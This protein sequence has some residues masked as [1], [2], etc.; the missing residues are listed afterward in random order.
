MSDGVDLPDEVVSTALPTQAEMER[1]ESILSGLFRKSADEVPPPVEDAPLIVTDGTEETATDPAILVQDSGP[2]PE[3]AAGLTPET[4]IATP[5]PRRRGVLGWLRRGAVA[6][7][8]DLV[9]SED[10]EV[11]ENI[12]PIDASI[13]DGDVEPEPVDIASLDPDIAIETPPTELVEPRKRR[14]L[15]GSSAPV[16]TAGMALQ[17]TAPGAALPFGEVARVC[18]ARAGDLGKLVEQAARKG[19]GYKLYDS[20]PDSAF[21]RAFYVTGFSD[22]CARQ[23]TAALAIFGSPE[24]HEQ[25]RYGLPAE[26]YPYSTT[27]RAYEKVKAKICN[28][29]RNQPCGV[30]VSRLEKTTAFVSVYEHFG[31]NARWADMLLHDGALLATSVK[32]P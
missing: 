12:G 9:V 13:T 5:E 30:R 11:G 17:D 24:F 7:A 8:E 3:A 18:G 20:A 4:P 2:A 26:E 31:E 1:E 28:V 29:R 10:I 6:E 14:G 21:P 23:F 19:R 25:L 16:Q 27:D 15:F 32:T 22:N